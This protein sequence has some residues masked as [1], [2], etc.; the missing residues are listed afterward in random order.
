MKTV[1]FLL[2]LLFAQ[3]PL[4]AQEMDK[5]ELKEYFYDAEF[6]FAEEE[7]AD[8]LSD[9]A[10][11]YNNGYKD[12]SNINYKIGIC[13]LNL[14]G[15]KD[16][17]IDF[18]LEAV[19]NASAKYKEGNLKQNLAPLDAYLYLGN[20]Y[21]VNNMLDKAIETYNKY[22]EIANSEKE[23]N[24][25]DQQ[26]AAC[27]IAIMYMNNPLQVRITNLGDSI[28]GTSSNF[29][30]VIS[31]NGKTLVYM[32]ELPFYDAVY[33]SKYLNGR[34]TS[35][36]NIT[37]QI[38]S[39]GDQYV[40]S[41][42]Y[43]GVILY[44][45]KEDAFNSDIYTSDL[46][47]GTW[48]KSVPLIGQ[49][50]NT[51]YWESHASISKDGKTLYFTSNRKDGL[52]DMDIYKSQLLSNGQWGKAINLGSPVNTAL[53]ED[54]PFICENDSLLYFS[55][56]G[57]KTM[58]GYDIFVAQLNQSGQWSEPKNLQYPLNSTDDDLFYYPW[59]NDRVGYVSMIRPEGYGKEDIY[60]VQ[61]Y[62]DKPLPML[63]SELIPEEATAVSA[64]LSQAKPPDTGM[65]SVAAEPVETIEPAELKIAPVS[66]PPRNIALTPVYFAFDSYQL[67]D[68]DILQL[69]KVL[70]L[71][72]EYQ[73]IRVKLTGHSDAKGPADYNQKLSEKRA[74]S[75]MD[76]LVNN[77]I[78]SGRIDAQ[79][80]GEQ[81]FAAINSNPDGAD[82]PEGRKLNRRVEFEFIGLDNT[83]INITYPP[84]P[85]NLRYRE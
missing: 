72:K 79:G 85:E 74:S 41:I 34:W 81:K 50:I 12:N 65:P 54:T 33:Y 2:L 73:N 30:G 20:S 8:A 19:K 66:A 55:S 37:P 47:N 4:L 35:P 53:N 51:K 52:G 28:N 21:R 39:D 84:I 59:H 15:Q 75:V 11:L 42:S 18:L 69:D 5:S 58:G 25:A 9:Y 6:F 76:Y 14:P 3:V 82:N 64:E 46:A 40:T 10:E 13:Y 23:I 7:Y 57:H 45:T 24:Y 83:L 36:V 60:A 38:Q 77:N 26:I 44:L 70:Q 16:K 27:N 22:K 32:N 31:G 78:E 1:P 61:P 80:M 62:Q 56:Q 17:A 49:D 71:L 48:S 43:D 63:L 67:T 29:K 68:A